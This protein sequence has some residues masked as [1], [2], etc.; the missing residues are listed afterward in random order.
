MSV[1]MRLIPPKIL[2][3]PRRQL[4]ISH[5]VLDV[6]V[7]EVGL[8]RPRV[9]AL[10]RQCETA[11]VPQHVWMRLETELSFYA[12]PF[13]H[14]SETGRGEGRPRSEVNTKGDFGACS[15]WSRRSERN[16]SPMIG[17][18]LGLPCLTLRT[19]MVAVPKSS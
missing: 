11:G 6:L 13:H 17:W 10:R 18:V 4:G 9:V 8:K 15:R 3:T 5:G 16:S 14:P 12:R 19:W 2:E 7:T 1:R